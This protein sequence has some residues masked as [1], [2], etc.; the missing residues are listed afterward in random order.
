MF[1][2]VWWSPIL[3]VCL[4]VTPL[5]APD[6][7][8]TVTSAFIIGHCWSVH[9]PWASYLHI[10]LPLLIMSWWYSARCMGNINFSQWEGEIVT[11]GQSEAW[12]A[13]WVRVTSG[14]S[15]GDHHQAGSPNMGHLQLMNV[16]CHTASDMDSRPG[17]FKYPPTNIF[18]V[19]TRHSLHFSSCIEIGCTCVHW[20]LE[21]YG[22]F[23][24]LDVWPVRCG[25]VMR[26]GYVIYSQ[27]RIWTF[28]KW[29]M[30]LLTMLLAGPAQN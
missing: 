12:W 7:P 5:L 4:L 27:I 20:P 22:L 25:G 24:C 19:T 10:S 9:S 28:E 15:C 8:A 6:W 11:L 1:A 30:K 26:M 17:F 29:N 21:M 18:I 23:W 13:W 16:G 2:E 14:H 3:N